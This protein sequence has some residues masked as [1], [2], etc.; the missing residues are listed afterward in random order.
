[1]SWNTQSTLKTASQLPIEGVDEDEMKHRRRIRVQTNFKR[2]IIMR[3]DPEQGD[4]A[5]NHEFGVLGA[6]RLAP[7]ERLGGVEEQHLANE[8]VKRIN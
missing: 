1:M 3:V 7:R 4:K 8:T 2:F 5:V 6:E